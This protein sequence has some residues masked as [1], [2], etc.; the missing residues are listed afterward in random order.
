MPT[1]RAETGA[2]RGRPGGWYSY[3][4]LR[5]VP[6][7]DRGEFLNVGVI[8]F[9]R[10]QRFLEARLAFDEDRLRAIAPEIDL[11]LVRRHLAAVPA[12]CAGSAEGGPIAA[13]ALSE[14]FHQ[15]TAPTSTVI[16]ASAVH[17][18]YTD[19][20]SATLE[21]LLDAFVRLPPHPG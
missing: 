1:D 13:L 19:D 21:E 16:Q 11:S 20:P 12:I 4:I 6:R 14:R 15:L 8:L 2:H 18:G 17:A 3:A 9:A 10:T 7:V 5:V